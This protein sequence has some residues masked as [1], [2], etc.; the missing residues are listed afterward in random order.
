MGDDIR[1]ENG[2]VVTDFKK[3]A[4][5]DQSVKGLKKMYKENPDELLR[6]RMKSSRI[7]TLPS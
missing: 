1:Y 4:S 7:L 5:T 3:R 6:V 2:H